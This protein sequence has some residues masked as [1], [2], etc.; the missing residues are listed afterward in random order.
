MNTCEQSLWVVA[1][2]GLVGGAVGT[3]NT[4]VAVPFQE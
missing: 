1:F 4:E 2:H 3:A